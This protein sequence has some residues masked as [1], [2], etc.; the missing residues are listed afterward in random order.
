M[1]LPHRVEDIVSLFDKVPDEF[2]A[3]TEEG[4]L[5]DDLMNQLLE[6][7]RVESESEEGQRGETTRLAIAN[8]ILPEPGRQG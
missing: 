5:L 8:C 1:F 7:W 6:L 3:E 2:R 4:Q